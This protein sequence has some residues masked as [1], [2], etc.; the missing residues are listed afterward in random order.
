MKINKWLG[1]GAGWIFGGPIGAIIGF[2]VGSIVDGTN[3]QVKTY[4]G[5][6]T[7]INDFAM[8]MLVLV[9]AMMKADGKI[10]LSELEY[11]KRFLTKTFGEQAAAELTLELR[12]ML[13]KDI[14]VAEVCAQIKDHL[15][16]HSRLEMIHLLFG[17]AQSD[18]EIH[19][20][21]LS[22]LEQ[23]TLGLGV[24]QSDFLSIKAM[25]IEETDSAYKT[26]ALEKTAAIDEIKKAYK[27]LAIEHHPD[28]VSYLGVDVQNA[29]KEKFQKINE[30]YEKI[31]KE[32][33]FV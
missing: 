15:D 21:E 18:G 14:N 27:K 12:E 13:K 31:K 5:G 26:L 28:K 6:A 10:M 32:R 16:Y 29:A 8:S 25:F 23:I 9:A 33:G 22:L 20:D 1:L 11:V 17:V 19:P 3:L 4:R 2:A 30:A 24:L 7:T